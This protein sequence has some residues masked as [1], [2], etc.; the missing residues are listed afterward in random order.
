MQRREEGHND[1]VNLVRSERMAGVIH[2]KVVGSCEDNHDKNEA[3]NIPGQRTS[4]VLPVKGVSQE[5]Q[6]HTFL[7]QHG[8]AEFTESSGLFFVFRAW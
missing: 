4:F 5:S 6:D 1:V 3:G 2:Q 7:I 8:S